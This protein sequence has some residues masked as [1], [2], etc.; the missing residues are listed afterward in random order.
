[1]PRYVGKQ[2]DAKVH[3]IDAN[4][5]PVTGASVTVKVLDPQGRDWDGSWAATYL[6]DG[7]YYTS[8]TPDEG[9]DWTVIFSCGNPKF[10]KAVVYHISYPVSFSAPLNGMNQI[11]PSDTNWYVLFTSYQEDW[12]QRK[13]YYFTIKQT[14]NENAQKTVSVLFNLD[15][16][17]SIEMELTLD[18]GTLYYVVLRHTES[19]NYTYYVTT[20]ETMFLHLGG[21]DDNGQQNLAIPLECRNFDV[22]ARIPAPGPGTNQMVQAHIAVSGDYS[23]NQDCIQ[24]A[25]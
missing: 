1:M 5:D 25:P 12:V 4:G 21:Q 16:V 2:L 19:S 22:Q 11:F 13:L 20:A 9:G 17:R 3:L 23:A 24:G 15:S 7:I 6:S 10:T 18:S 14:N 8:F